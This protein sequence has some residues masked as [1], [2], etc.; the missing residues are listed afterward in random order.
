VRVIA[1]LA[2]I[3]SRE[4]FLPQV[5]A[6]LRPQVDDLCV[7]LNGYDR[8]PQSIH[9]YGAKFAASQSNQ[10]AERKF[11]RADASE[12][13]YLSCDDDLIYPSDYVETMCRHVAEW[14]GKAICTAHGRVYEGTPRDVHDVAPGSI[15]TYLMDVPKGRLI[16]HGGT[17]VMAWD[18]AHVRMPDDWPLENIA[19]MQ[20]AIW[21]QKNEVPMYLVPHSGKW[22]G[23]LAPTDPDGLFKRS[24]REHHVRRNQLLR[25]HDWYR[26]VE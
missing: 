25:T 12:G 21:A 4:R 3:P 8:I 13:L 20:V 5:L 14:G 7:W 9:D 18:L 10:G 11:F 19:D 16:N 15:G 2:T 6:S 17:G 23:S 26:W 22:V 24:Q 1:A